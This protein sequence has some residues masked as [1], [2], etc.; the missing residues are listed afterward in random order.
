[1]ALERLIR[2]V[3]ADSNQQQSVGLAASNAPSSAVSPDPVPTTRRRL[4]GVGLGLAAATVAGGLL[5]PADAL[6]AIGGPRKLSLK[7]LNTGESFTS[8]YWRDGQYVGDALQKLNILLRDHR[9]NEVHRIDPQLFD[10]LTLLSHRLE[11]GGA[12][13]QI[14][15]AYRAPRTNAKRASESRGVAR[16]S[17]HIQGMALDIRMPERNLRGLYKT[18]VAMGEGGVGY[19]RRSNF[20]HVDTGPVR[21]WG[22]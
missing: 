14:V 2:R 17:F 12:P 5:K 4:L 16:N 6:A 7:N 15:S 8:V 11:T 19:Y 21:T 13:V 18:A 3:T 20:V 22:G 1:M 9:A 10:L